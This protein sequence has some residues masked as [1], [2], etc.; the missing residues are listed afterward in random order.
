MNL[1]GKI[2]VVLILIASAIF[3]TMGMMVYATHQNW[4]V[5]VMGANGKGDDPESYHG[6]LD[7]AYKDQA[8]LHGDIDKLQNQLAQEKALHTQALVKTENERDI[9][10][11]QATSLS[12]DLEKLATRLDKATKDVEIAQQTVTA[13]READKKLRDDIRDA[14]AKTDEQLKIATQ[15]TDE[16]NIK[17][18]QLADLKARNEQLA[19]DFAKAKNVL[20]TLGRTPFDSAEP[21]LVRGQIMAMDKED[22]VEI[23]IGSDDGLREG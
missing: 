20:A 13:L 12:A 18:G 11:K 19:S 23:S 4:Q 3:M 21:P 1:V 5:A 10:A 9:L 22:R 16:L 8:K 14:N 17:L 6:K 7:T 15:K 2:F